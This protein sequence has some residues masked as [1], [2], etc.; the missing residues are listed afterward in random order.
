MLGFD[1][2]FRGL[3]QMFQSERNFKTQLIVFSLVISL[4]IYLNISTTHW[5][6]ILLISALV[7]S[8]EI[9]NSAIEKSCNLITTEINPQ[10]ALI[11]DI[12]AA[13]VLLASLFAVV[14]GIMIFYPYIFVQ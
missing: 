8:L 6:S 2:A 7:L 12:S 4:G 11:K 3:L 9:I 10:I 5:I 14:I 1:H 13:A